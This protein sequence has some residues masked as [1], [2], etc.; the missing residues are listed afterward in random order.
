M[1][2]STALPTG[3]TAWFLVPALLALVGYV[4]AGW[5]VQASWSA[6]ALIAAW[7]LHWLAMLAHLLGWGLPGTGAH[8]GFAPALSTMAWMVLGVYGIES[9][10][11]PLPAVRRGLAVLGAVVVV[12]S[13]IFPGDG[14]V[15]AESP[16]APLHWVLGLASY[17]LFGAAVLH[18]TWLDRTERALRSAGRGAMQTPGVPLLTLEKLTFHL[19]AAGFLVLTVAIVLGFWLNDTWHWD[20]KTVFSLLGWT[21]FAA[22]LVGRRAFGWRGKRATR[23]LYVGT[24]LLLLAYVGSRFVFEVVLHRSASGGA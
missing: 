24:G 11:V 19:V 13:L 16:W 8:F 9:R 15:H 5:R 21:V 7:A 10:W 6:P 20:H 22:L 4:V 17:G 2:L 23:W 12:V 3:L 1:I 14:T 18:A